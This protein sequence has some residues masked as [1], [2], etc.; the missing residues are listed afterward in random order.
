MIEFRL[1]EIMEDRGLS[2]YELS[3]NTGINYQTLTKLY[4]GDN[5]AIQYEIL[6]KLCFFLDCTPGD[7]LIYTPDPDAIS[8]DDFIQEIANSN[9]KEAQQIRLEMY[10]QFSQKYIKRKK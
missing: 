8:P 4:N 5:K 7:L 9:S 3:K 10:R 6:N 2:R 1:K